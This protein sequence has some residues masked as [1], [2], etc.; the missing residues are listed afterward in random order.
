[1]I[2]KRFPGL[3]LFGFTSLFGSV[4]LLTTVNVNLAAQQ[5]PLATSGTEQNSPSQAVIQSRPMRV[6]VELALVN[7]T[8]TDVHNHPII[9]L[10][11][12]SF[13]LFED[14]IEQEMIYFS[15][16]DVP[17]S[18]GLILDVSGS[19]ADKL[20]KV[21]D[22]AVQFLKS[23]NPRDEFFAVLF[24][25]HAELAS[26]FFQNA[27][28]LEGHA[29]IPPAKGG[30]ALL[31][32]VYLGLQQMRNA[33]YARRV[34]LIIS[35]GADNHSRYSRSDIKRFLKEC[36]CQVYAIGVFEPIWLRGRTPEELDGPSLLADLT[37]VTGGRVFPVTRQHEL[38]DIA[39]KIGMMLRNQ[40]VL[41]YRPGNK[42][43]DLHWRKIKVKL[44]P[45]KGLPPLTVSAK[46][47]YYAAAM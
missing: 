43:H 9:G 27:D 42:A 10:H 47:G 22:A 11:Q 6:D 14:N 19:M 31:D 12:D 8:V 37:E 15:S 26:D 36:D 32:A 29:R 21:R 39:A 5:L 25:D 44:R 46:R 4:V 2:L 24:A 40:Y 3:L 13:R 45:P 30:T 33:R 17:V 38:P 34:L 23:A 41:G 1:M 18:L 7:V 20:N 16:E 35:D 28:N